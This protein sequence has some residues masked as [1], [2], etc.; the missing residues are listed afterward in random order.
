MCPA[1]FLPRGV[2]ATIRT[3][4]S[5]AL[6][7]ADQVFHDEAVDSDANRPQGQIDDWANRI[8]G[9]RPFVQQDHD[10]SRK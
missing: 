9:Q 6:L 8:G 5:S 10:G 2:R 1:C 7:P 3:R 4:R